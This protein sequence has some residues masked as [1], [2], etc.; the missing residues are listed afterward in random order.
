MLSFAGIG[1]GTARFAFPALVSG[2]A[3]CV[4]LDFSQSIGSNLSSGN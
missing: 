4:L 3:G 1:F 2:W